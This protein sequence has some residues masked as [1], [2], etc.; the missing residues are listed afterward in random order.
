[1]GIES[2]FAE[3]R[4]S[5]LIKVN[6]LVLITILRSRYLIIAQIHN[7]MYFL[8]V[9]VAQNKDSTVPLLFILR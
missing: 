5:L 3:E 4:S 8:N 2:F 1:M 9:S 6:Y 7:C